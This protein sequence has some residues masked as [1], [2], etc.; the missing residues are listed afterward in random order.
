MFLRSRMVP[1][2]Q[3][4]APEEI[5]ET[6]EE[7]EPA[8]EEP[9][10]PEEA[11][12]PAEPTEEIMGLGSLEL[13]EE[14][15]LVEEPGGEISLEELEPTTG[16]EESIEIDIGEKPGAEELVLEEEPAA[17]LESGE[18]LSLDEDLATLETEPELEE[19][20]ALQGSS[21]EEV[22]GQTMCQNARMK[23]GTVLL[24]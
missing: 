7:G 24:S 2:E 9:L 11:E 22:Q 1:A 10:V 16:E 4:E 5:V 21:V 14:E 20:E 23:K 13:E 12:G 19:A 18:E 3:V 17:E 8:E 6:L 15:A